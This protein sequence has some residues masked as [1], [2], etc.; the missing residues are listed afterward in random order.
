[1]LYCLPL[2]IASVN[3]DEENEN[4]EPNATK[5]SCIEEAENE[6]KAVRQCQILGATYLRVCMYVRMYVCMY[7]H[8]FVCMYVCMY[9]R[10]YVCMYVC[11]YICMYVCIYHVAWADQREKQG[12]N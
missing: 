5:P 6:N 2:I 12:Y 3:F 4:T 8:T 7:V 10:M 9:V 11:M 1:M